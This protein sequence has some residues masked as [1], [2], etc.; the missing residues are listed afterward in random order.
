MPTGINRSIIHEYLIIPATPKIS[1]S[2]IIAQIEKDKG[3]DAMVNQKIRLPKNL[4]FFK[5]GHPFQ[6]YEN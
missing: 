4:L 6:F 1:S 2:P 3:R 5:S